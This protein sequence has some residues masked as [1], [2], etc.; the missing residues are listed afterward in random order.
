MDAAWIGALTSSALWQFCMHIALLSGT[1]IGGGMIAVMPDVHR[2]VVE[3]N[4][5]VSSEQ[6]TS[7]FAM[8]QAS[9]GPNFLYIALIGWQV[10]GWKGTIAGSIA[11]AL[12]PAL[13]CYAVIRLGSGRESGALQKAFRRSLVPLSA[14]L[15]LAS[16]WVLANT[17]DDSWRAALM[18]IVFVVVLLR[19]RVHP[20]WLIALGALLGGLG[21]L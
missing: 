21:L 18:T 7:A 16:G 9:P 17:V 4:H 12:P 8:A 2:F 13:V 6:F 19:T 20:L 5:W 15:L 11:V 3:T 10:A 14:G 1:A